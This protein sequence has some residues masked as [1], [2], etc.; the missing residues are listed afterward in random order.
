[1]YSELAMAIQAAKVNDKSIAFFLGQ[2][3]KTGWI[4]DFHMNFIEHCNVC[5]YDL[6]MVFGC[7]IPEE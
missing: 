6:N 7:V 3:I 5:C 1:M 2:C 4:R